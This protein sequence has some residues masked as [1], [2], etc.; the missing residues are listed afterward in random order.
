MK[1]RTSHKRET[2]TWSVVMCV[3]EAMQTRPFG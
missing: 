3:A 2:R 1:A